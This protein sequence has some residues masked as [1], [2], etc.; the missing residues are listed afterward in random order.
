MV[1]HEAD[2][3][4][5]RFVRCGKVR[6]VPKAAV[7]PMNVDLL[8]QEAT[9]AHRF[10]VYGLE[11]E[12][13]EFMYAEVGGWKRCAVRRTNGSHKMIVLQGSSQQVEVFGELVVPLHAETYK[14]AG[15]PVLYPADSGLLEL[16][17]R[18]RVHKGC[19]HV[20]EFGT[21][22]QRWLLDSDIE[23]FEEALYG[24]SSALHHS[25]D[26]GDDDY[27]AE[28]QKDSSPTS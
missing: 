18:L 21:C 1:L 16:G 15:R 14:L 10:S 7:S 13:W 20:L 17:W 2:Q 25:D 3:C 5:I 22:Q 4:E 27:E 11:S 26:D 19:A 12:S 8:D 23:P 24:M 9:E 6:V 28:R